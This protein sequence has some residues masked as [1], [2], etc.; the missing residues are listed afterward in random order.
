MDS[1]NPWDSVQPTAAAS[2][3]AK[4][5][6]SGVLTRETLDACWKGA[7]CFV[8]FSEVEKIAAIN[9][10]IMQKEL[11]IELLKL[12]KETADVVHPFFLADKFQ[13]LQ[14]MNSHLQEVL[15]QKTKLRK[16]LMKPLCQENLV[17]EANFHRYVAELLG[18][19]ISFIEKLDA[20]L[21]TVRTIP[22]LKRSLAEMERAQAKMNVL[23]TEVEELTEKILKWREQQGRDLVPKPFSF[24]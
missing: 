2:V 13:A 1:V 22:Q 11:E 19:A 3:L 21:Q 16:R 15:K 20:Y 10:E 23:V 14:A 24:L 18:L 17:I 8:R 9:S 4:C 6:S 12:E 7:P 5:V